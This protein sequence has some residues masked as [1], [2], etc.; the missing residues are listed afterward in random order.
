MTNQEV[1]R[2]LAA[3]LSADVK[4]FSRLRS[5]QDEMWR[6]NG[7]KMNRL[8]LEVGA[9]NAGVWGITLDPSNRILVTGSED[10]TMRVWNISGRGELL[11]VLRPTIGE[12]EEGHIFA[13]ALS[14]DARTVAC[15]GRTGSPKQGD[16]CVYLFDRATGAL[17]RRLGGLPGWVQHLVYTPDGRFL[18]VVTGEGG[19]K[20]SWSGM[21]IFR[22]PDY[23]LV[24]EDRDYGDYVKWVESNP[25]GSKVAPS[26]MVTMPLRPGPSRQC[27]TSGLPGAS[28]HGGSPSRPMAPAWQWDFT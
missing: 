25:T 9:H 6:K 14:P 18:A 20:A 22:L 12:G 11:R 28:I 13:V 16:A 26:C 8:R 24:A 19:G 1:K 7:A 23:T 15:G 21:K 10:K 17:I 2:K 3:I 5:N 27:P 4:R